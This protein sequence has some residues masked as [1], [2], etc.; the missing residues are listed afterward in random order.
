MSLLRWALKELLFHPFFAA[1]FVMNLSLGLTGLVA[2][3]S[4]REFL[5]ESVS[6]KSRGMLGADLG[7]SSRQPIDEEQIQKADEVFQ[8][9]LRSKTTE[10]FSMVATTSGKS[11][12]VQIKS[13]DQNFPFYGGILLKKSGLAQPPYEILKHPRA[14][15]YPEVL[16]QLKI[17]LGDPLKIGQMT[18]TVSDV[19]MDDQASGLSTSMAPRIYIGEDF[20]PQT[21]LL[22][23]NSLAWFSVLYRKDLDSDSLVKLTDQLFQDKAM[24]ESVRIYTHKTMS[25]QI[26]RLTDYVSD[27]LGL[28]SAAAL[29]LSLIGSVFLFRSY[30]HRRYRTMGVWKSLGL[31]TVKIFKIYLYQVLLLS[32][33]SS[34]FS[35]A[36]SFVVLKALVPILQNL[37]SVPL[38]VE[39]SF[40]ALMISLLVSLSSSLIF[41]LPQLLPLFNSS[42]LSLFQSEVQ[43]E[44]RSWVSFLFVFFGASFFWL[45]C[46]YLSHSWFNGTLFVA[47]FGLSGTLLL[48]IAFG[49]L[50]GLQSFTRFLSPFW[51]LS[52]SY[53]T[54]RPRLFYLGF[55]SIAMGSLLLNIT[56]QLENSLQKDLLN[57]ETK[58]LP[59]FFLFDLQEEQMKTYSDFLRSKSLEADLIAPM[60]R[61]RLLKVNDQPFEKENASSKKFSREQQREAQFRNRGFNLSY[62]KQLD[63]SETIIAGRPFSSE[64]ETEVGELSVERRFAERLGL[65]INDR[66]T[67]DIQGVPLE[68]IIVNLRR[69]KWTSFRPNFFILFQPGFLEMAPKTFIS[70]LSTIPPRERS[71]FQDDLVEELPNVSVVDVS[72]VVEKLMG[73]N[74]QIGLALTTMAYLSMIIGLLVL[75]A[76]ISLQS[77]TQMRDM[78]LLKLLGAKNSYVSFSFVTQF[79]LLSFLAGLFGLALSLSVSASLSIFIFDTQFQLSVGPPLIVF[80]SLQILAGLLSLIGSKLSSTKIQAL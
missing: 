57:S 7:L 12:L 54:S 30:L 41:S 52:V 34:L 51:R 70:S 26:H 74:E 3:E 36:L 21:Q 44:G 33:A 31:S 8:T 10:S 77:Q 38:N 45:L 46:V 28:A 20:L 69:V 64:N 78:S 40:S 35:F 76:I 23:P 24:D 56:P 15:V 9:K 65:K 39:L 18:F 79:L 11:R 32:L 17:Q 61:A 25:D 50:K 4:V 67:F 14:W 22:G 47:L 55:F 73:I 13:I 5:S 48:I 66:L 29:F 59:D 72:R 63:P 42:T 43:L 75:F 62:R 27:F 58:I 60:V 68:G 71:Q 80:L 2:L 19:V 53:L 1:L 16:S 37:T 49:L 6:E